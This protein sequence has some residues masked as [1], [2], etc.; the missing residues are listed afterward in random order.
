MTRQ[1]G[2]IVV[3]CVLLSVFGLGVLVGRWHPTPRVQ[4]ITRDNVKTVLVDRPTLVPTDVVRYVAD[5]AEVTKLLNE[6]AAAE[7]KIAVLTE[8]IAALKASGTG[9]VTYV[10]RLVPGET[11]TVRATHFQDWRLTFDATEASASYRLAQRFE[12]LAAVGK[13]ADGKPTAAVRLFE[14][15]PGETRTLLTDAKTTIVATVPRGSRWR[16]SAAIQAGVGLSSTVS[17]TKAATAILALPWLRRGT[18]KAAEDNT[19]AVLT[20]AVL[21]GPGIHEP[22]LLPV[23][24]NLARRLPLFGDIWVSPGISLAAGKVGRVGVFLTATF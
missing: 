12:A 21:L 20:P 4:I 17:G 18:S 9:T 16:L 10:D 7:N 14:I 2:L 6:A 1:T 22:A 24:V 23:S 3:A 5:K 11:R 8:T 13:S 19:W 15:G